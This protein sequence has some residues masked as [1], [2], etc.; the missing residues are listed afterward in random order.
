MYLKKWHISI[1]FVETLH[2]LESLIAFSIKSLFPMDNN[3][4]L[5]FKRFL[6]Q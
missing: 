1:F 2:L 3:H 6:H 4:F 5:D